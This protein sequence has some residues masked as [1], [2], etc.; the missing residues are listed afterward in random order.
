MI[1]WTEMGFSDLVS[2]ETGGNTKTLQSDYLPVGKYPIVDQGQSLIGGY[3]NDV[4]RVCK[5]ELPVV[6]FGDHT[7]C[8]KFIDFPFCLG[9]DGTKVLRPKQPIDDRYLFY[10]LQRIHIPDAGYSRHFKYLKEGKIP[11]PGLD[12]QK[13]IVV[14]LDQADELRRKRDLAVNCLSKLSQALFI[15]M[16]G[17]PVTNPKGFPESP[18]GSLIKVSSGGALVAANQKGGKYPVFGG[19][20]INGWHDEPSVASGT[21]I[22]GRVGVYCGSVHVTD[23]PSWVTDNALIVSKKQQINTNYLAAALRLAN[24]NQ[25]AGRSAQPLV[26]G[27]RIYPV[28]ILLPS[29]SEQTKFDERLTK[30]IEISSDLSEAQ[31]RSSG[32]FEALQRRAFRGEL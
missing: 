17:D 18:L 13:R 2:D 8:F 9:A 1:A 29:E 22:V 20:G 32:L 16:F 19:N 12:E 5:A 26:S 30:I 11:L 6:I 21:I 27:S 25:Y 31:D 4:T 3:T 15:N 7:K 28:K 23:T 14:I 24:L 10:A